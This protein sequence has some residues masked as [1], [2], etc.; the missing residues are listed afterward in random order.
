MVVKRVVVGTLDGVGASLAAASSACASV[1]SASV[2]T[3]LPGSASLA[4]SPSEASS[5]STS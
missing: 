4:S 5:D 1:A 2:A 3:M